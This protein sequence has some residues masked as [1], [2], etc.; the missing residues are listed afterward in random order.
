[1]TPSPSSSP[2]TKAAVSL[3]RILLMLVTALVLIALLV[4]SDV[5]R[6]LR[7]QYRWLGAFVNVVEL[8]TLRYGINFEHVIAFVLLG[9]ASRAA[10]PYTSARWLLL[11]VAVLAVATE[12]VQLWI[13]GRTPRM[14]DVLTD[15]G[16]ALLGTWLAWLLRRL[17]A[18]SAR[19]R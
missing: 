12:L 17:A 15:I 7:L 11:W 19:T 13:P 5:L 6:F 3:A 16:S 10:L 18:G 4:P 9:A 8:E 14:V 2:P 1:V